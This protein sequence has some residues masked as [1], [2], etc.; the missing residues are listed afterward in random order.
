MGAFVKVEDKL[1]YQAIAKHMESVGWTWQ[2]AEKSPTPTELTY[3][4][5][6]MIAKVKLHRLKKFESGGFIVSRS[7]NTLTVTFEE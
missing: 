3:H 2:D 6:K 7:G 4:V 5:Y 1:D